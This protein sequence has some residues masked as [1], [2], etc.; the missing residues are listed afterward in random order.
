ERTFD[1]DLINNST[2]AA[3]SDTLIDSSGAHF[4][5]IPSPLTSRDNGRQAASDLNVLSKSIKTLD[6]TGDA[7]SD[8]DPDR[9]HLVGL[10]LG[11]M[12][13]IVAADHTAVRTLSASAPGGVITQLLLDSATFG[14]RI[15]AALGAGLVIDSYVYDLFVSD[16]QAAVDSGDPVNHIAGAQDAVPLH[17]MEVVG[18]AVIPNSA[19][20]RLIVAG[21]LTKLTALG[22]NPVAPGSG[23]YTIFTAG[24]HGTLIRPDAS[25]AATIEMQKQ[26]V[27][28]V[29]TTPM[30][31]GPFVVIEDVTVLDLE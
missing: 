31:G 18:D 21:G 11:A 23:G 26:V 2:S 4:I 29:A 20:D 27:K 30:A 7:V 8:I 3:T 1:V 28:F 22:P 13:G 15:R 14:P 16:L 24:D 12:T 25:L 19:T 17:L 5:N 10:S 9:V 6:L